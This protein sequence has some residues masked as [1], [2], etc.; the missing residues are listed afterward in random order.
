MWAAKAAAL[1]PSVHPAIYAIVEGK[2]SDFERDDGQI[3]RTAMKRRQVQSSSKI[4]DDKGLSSEAFM[5]SAQEM[6]T[7]L[8]D[9]IFKT[10]V[11]GVEEAVKETGNEITIKKGQLAKEDFLRMIEMTNHGFDDAGK[12]TNVFMVSPEMADQLVKAESEWKA[13]KE[14]TAKFEEVKRRKREEFDE[15]EARRRLVD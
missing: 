8:A 13:D 6:G 9:E 12:S 11:E 5:K 10:I 3:R 7:A 2:V 1:P 14:F 4:E 15:R